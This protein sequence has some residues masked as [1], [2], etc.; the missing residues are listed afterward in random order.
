V[1]EPTVKRAIGFVNGQNLFYAAK[2]AF[3][4]SYPNFDP[5][6]LTEVVAAAQGWTPLGTHFYSGVPDPADNPFWSHFWNAKLA[7]MGTQGVVSYTRPLRYRNQTIALPGGGSTTVL[8]GQEKGI[9]VRIALDI[10]RLARSGDYDVALVFSQDQDLSEVADE[11]RGIARDQGRWIKIA[12]A[13]PSSPT[14]TN[15][16]GVN[17]TDWIRLERATYDLALDPRDYRPRPTPA[18]PTA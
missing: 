1:I 9:D 6:R 16:R 12:S 4:Y 15:R 3:G 8:V 10:V 14:S 13:Y 7:V 11:I 2:Q 18:E 5:K 17:R